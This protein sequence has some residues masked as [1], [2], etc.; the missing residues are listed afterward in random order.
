MNSYG[1]V[2]AGGNVQFVARLTPQNPKL[3]ID[4]KCVMHVCDNAPEQP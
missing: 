4:N 2:R 1:G 3:D